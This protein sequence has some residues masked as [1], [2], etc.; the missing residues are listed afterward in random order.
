LPQCTRLASRTALC[1]LRSQTPVS[2]HAGFGLNRLFCWLD[3]VGNMATYR[4]SWVPD[5][6]QMQS[7][8]NFHDLQ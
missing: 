8:C 2:L 3:E 5:S 6:I 1:V 4:C 7:N